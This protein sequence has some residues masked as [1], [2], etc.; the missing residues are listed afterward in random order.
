MT[1]PLLSDRERWLLEACLREPAE[2]RAA[3][4]AWQ[5]FANPAEMQ[6]REL[7]LVPLLEANLRR[8]GLQDPQLQGTG[9]GWLRGQA[10]HVWL[11]GALRRRALQQALLTLDAAGVA[12]V[13][14]KGAA[15]LARW[16]E[17]AA[18]RPTGDFDLLLPPEQLHAA[19][20][21]LRAIGWQA[22]PPALVT[23][24]DL[25]HFHAQG[26]TDSTG[27]C[28]DLHWRPAE[29]IADPGHAAGV[30]A[31]AQSLPFLG[32]TRR[33]AGLTDHLFVLLAHAFHDSVIARH[34]W[35]AE[36]ALLLRHAE[37]AA[38]DWPL[39]QALCQGYRL[40]AWAAA[41][42]GLVA[43]VARLTLPAG[44]LPPRRWKPLQWRE[45][46]TRQ[47][48]APGPLARWSRRRGQ[49]AR[50][51]ALVPPLSAGVPSAVLRRALRQAPP[52][53][54]LALLPPGGFDLSQ[55]AGAASFRHGWSMP[56]PQGRWTD[57]EAALLLM[58]IAAPPGQPLPLRLRLFPDHLPETP[59]FT[60]HLWAGGTTTLWRCEAGQPLPDVW[61]LEG[62]PLLWRGTAILPLLFRFEGLPG[63]RERARR[64][65]DQRRL[66][67]HLQRLDWG[68][69]VALPW[70]DR[71]LLLAD[72]AVAAMAWSGWG[73]AEADGRW[74]LGPEARLRLR[75]PERNVPTGLR[76]EIASGFAA[77]AA[78]QAV[79][80]L[81]DDMPAGAFTLPLKGGAAAPGLLPGGAVTLAL[82]PRPGAVL[83]LRLRIARPTSPRGLRLSEDR[84]ALGLMLR[85]LVPLGA[86]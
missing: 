50:G 24:A 47:S 6:G 67:L 68:E 25:Q 36:V 46:A 13:L 75:L 19:M 45:V 11:T 28:I 44:A 29:A 54:A 10:K 26:L 41:A 12:V 62:V 59:G 63:L 73:E 22:P 31:R 64:G 33:I 27:G 18:G 23:A 83:E 79:E 61:A 85:R 70:L 20:A 53:E 40:Q 49:A 86:G 43:E 78:G 84:R 76:L 42:L 34:D 3:F 60:A 71:P 7:R 15:L 30:A 77:G 8:A 55:D 57:G 39:F 32:S 14:M 74:T 16:P 9:L 56:E 51:T 81:L 21:A 69:P 1:V 52:P 72:P 35:V 66:G 82:P 17:A 80:L 2:A 38:W 48:I 37:P 4:A 58:R 65:L 5:P